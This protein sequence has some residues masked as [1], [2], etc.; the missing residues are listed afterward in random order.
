MLCSPEFFLKIHGLP[1]KIKAE[2][3]TLAV[4]C[5][6]MWTSEMGESAEEG[7]ALTS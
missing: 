4:S 3:V 5:E 6:E 7:K 2:N 1:H